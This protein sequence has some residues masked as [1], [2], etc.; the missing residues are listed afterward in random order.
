[1]HLA[2]LAGEPRQYA[3]LTGIAGVNGAL[4]PAGRLLAHTVAPNL[5][6]T[7]SAYFL[8]AAQFIFLYNLVHSLF[9]GTPA[10]ENPWAATTLEWHP[11]LNHDPFLMF[12]ASDNQIIVVRGPCEYQSSG[13]GETFLPQWKDSMS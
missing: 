7:I 1:M 2:G 10:G 6:T 11:S 12:S 3:Q 9:R 13:A 8:V 4:S 5:H